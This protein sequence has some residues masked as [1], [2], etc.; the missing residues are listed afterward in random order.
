MYHA[1]NFSNGLSSV[2][3][4]HRIWSNEF[5]LNTLSRAIRNQL[6]KVE[7]YL[8]CVFSANSLFLTDFMIHLWRSS[9]DWKFLKSY[10]NLNSIKWTMNA[11][12]YHNFPPIIATLRTLCAIFQLFH[13][14]FCHFPRWK[15]RF[16]SPSAV[17]GVGV[18]LIVNG[19]L[20]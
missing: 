14:I 17:H 2:G 7:I 19:N 12:I 3:R 5:L 6:H 11:T 1:N 18:I 9:H 10:K 4:M 8:S 13:R 16:A 20:R 15:W